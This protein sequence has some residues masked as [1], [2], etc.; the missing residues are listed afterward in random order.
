MKTVQLYYLS[1]NPYGGWITF[2]AHL[3]K[4]LRA[5]G[6]WPTLYKVRVRSEHRNRPFGYGIDYRNVDLRTACSGNGIKLITA[7]AKKFK[8]ETAALIEAGAYLVLH[9]PTELKN[10]PPIPEERTIVIRQSSLGIVP[11][12]TFIRH[13]YERQC[14]NFQEKKTIHAV[15]TARIDFDKHT[16]I[17]LEANRLLPPELQVQLHGFENRLYG[18]FKLMPRF[19]EWEPVQSTHMF[20]R[21]I[22]AAVR[23]LL[24]A[25][26]AVDMS[27]IIGD[28]GGTQYTFLE[29]WDAGAVPV[30]HYEWT[31]DFPSDDMQPGLN[32]LEADSGEA[33]ARL[34][35][36][37]QK[38]QDP[39]FVPHTLMEAGYK[40]LE[41]HAPA[42]IGHQY[43]DVLGVSE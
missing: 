38:S 4:A 28:G 41:L 8:A 20:D 6:L 37:T 33:L 10:L 31:K 40:Q 25:Q 22:T 17:I 32:C 13:P 18:K 34:L 7:A 12:A 16:D 35:Q 30:I 42:T 26:Y 1:P 3:Y 15:S 19:P 21:T 2:T 14:T 29:A 9:D 43:A 11:G 5:A 24:P 27:I 36:S 23:F 39:V